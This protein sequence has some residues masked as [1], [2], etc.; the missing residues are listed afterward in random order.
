MF[1]N[2]FVST[3]C[4]YKIH[5]DELFKILYKFSFAWSNIRVL[6]NGTFFFFFIYMWLT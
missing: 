1:V 2:K 4:F 6:I 3:T 5:L